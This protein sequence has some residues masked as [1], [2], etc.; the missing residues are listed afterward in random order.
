MFLFLTKKKNAQEINFWYNFMC[1]TLGILNELDQKMQLWTLLLGVC[2]LLKPAS[3]KSEKNK[4]PETRLNVVE[5]AVLWEGLGKVLKI[6]TFVLLLDDRFLVKKMWSSGNIHTN[7][8]LW[9]QC[10]GVI[11]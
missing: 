7:Q 4:H 5:T 3:H 9:H 1:L 8:E 6:L 11:V 2:N 10:P